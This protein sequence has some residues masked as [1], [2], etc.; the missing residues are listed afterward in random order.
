V[1]NLI[2]TKAPSFSPEGCITYHD[3]VRFTHETAIKEMIRH[4]RHIGPDRRIGQTYNNSPLNL[5]LIDLGEGL[6]EGLTTCDKV[7]PEE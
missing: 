4:V 5:W 7:T 2:D 6:R 3:I 1:L